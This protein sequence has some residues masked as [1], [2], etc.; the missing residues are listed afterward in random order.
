MTK[1]FFIETIIRLPLTENGC[2]IWPFYKNRQQ[3]GIVNFKG[4]NRK[5]HRL[6]YMFLK[7]PDLSDN[8]V[9]MH[10]CDNSSCVNIEHLKEGTVA[11]NN[12]DML[13]KGR[14][15]TFSGE[16]HG[17]YLLSDEKVAKIKE[18][19]ATGK[20]TQR[21]LARQNGCSRAYISYLVTGRGR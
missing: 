10:T 9:V 17:M 14:N 18:D 12:L 19:Y 6:I 1:E 3:Y 5:A 2:K 8:L 4:K 13:N 21:Y 11:D 20:Y 16:L 7:N 15:I